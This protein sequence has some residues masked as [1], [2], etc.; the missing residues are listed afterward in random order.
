MPTALEN[1]FQRFSNPGTYRVTQ[2]STV[3]C[4]TSMPRSTSI[5]RLIG[6]PSQDPAGQRIGRYTV[7]DDRHPIDEHPLHPDRQL[8][9]RAEGRLV[10]DL[11]RIKHDDIGPQPGLEDAA[12]IETQTGGRQAREFSDSLFEAYASFLA[13]VFAEHAWEGPVG[14]RMRKLRAKQTIRR[15]ALAIVAERNPGLNRGKRN[16]GLAH[17]EDSHVGLRP[18]LDQDVEKRVLGVGAARLR[19]LGEAAALQIDQLRI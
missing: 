4:A 15:G 12:I 18:V 2:R 1:R 17:R 5:R 16:V 3:V 6:L 9:W 11:L 7:G 13:H 19:A 10:G 14:A 8:L